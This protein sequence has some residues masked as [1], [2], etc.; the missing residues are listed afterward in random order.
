MST[1]SAWLAARLGPGEVAGLQLGLREQGQHLSPAVAAHVGRGLEVL[2]RA[3]VV[4]ERHPQPAGGQ[5]AVVG[6]AV[7]AHPL[8]ELLVPLRGLGE[9]PRLGRVPAEGE[10]HVGDVGRLRVVGERASRRSPA[11][12]R[13]P[14]SRARR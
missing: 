11:P 9:A 4:V 13:S 2:L 6:G 7:L 14:A 5:P 8:P 3:R 12:W 1:P 10:Q